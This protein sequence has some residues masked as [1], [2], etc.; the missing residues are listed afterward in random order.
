MTRARVGL[1]GKL[2]CAGPR[3]TDQY[4]PGA[5]CLALFRRTRCATAFPWLSSSWPQA[6]RFRLKR[7]TF[8]PTFQERT[9]TGSSCTSGGRLHRSLPRTA[10]R[11]T[12]CH[13]R[14]R[15]ICPASSIACST[16]SKDGCRPLS[17][18]KPRSSTSTRQ[19]RRQWTSACSSREASSPSGTRVPRSHP[20]G[21]S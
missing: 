14:G 3:L 4:H 15:A 21:S 2:E 12:G 7:L 1:T 10:P 11:S 9:L 8:P 16:T 5:A 18:W 6:S 13:S 17:G 19:T 20:P